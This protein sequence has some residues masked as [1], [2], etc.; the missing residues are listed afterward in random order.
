MQKWITTFDSVMG[1]QHND[2]NGHWAKRILRSGVNWR[3]GYTHFS[4]AHPFSDW[5]RRWAREHHCHRPSGACRLS[6]SLPLWVLFDRLM[7]GGNTEC[8]EPQPRALLSHQRKGNMALAK[9]KKRQQTSKRKHT[10][11][12]QK[13]KFKHTL[14]CCTM[15]G[16]DGC[17]EAE[18]E[19]T[20]LINR[21]LIRSAATA[22][23]LSRILALINLPLVNR[24]CRTNRLNKLQTHTVYL[25]IMLVV[26]VVLFRARSG[27]I[28]SR[29]SIEVREKSDVS[30][31]RSK[32]GQPPFTDCFTQLNLFDC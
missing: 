17:E 21:P 23:P 16:F 12:K 1:W 28:W 5:M 3:E 26:V 18:E 11:N 6:I 9:K 20:V 22:R 13:H 32:R 4:L 10:S 8:S 14:H 19:C 15:A 30:S 2:T 7:S 29:G 27:A 25:M 31:R 24:Q